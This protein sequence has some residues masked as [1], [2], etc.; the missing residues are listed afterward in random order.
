MTALPASSRDEPVGAAYIPSDLTVC[1]ATTSGKDNDKQGVRRGKA[2]CRES[3]IEPIA[4]NM[5]TFQIN[6]LFSAVLSEQVFAASTHVNGIFQI[7][8]SDK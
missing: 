7:H 4:I 5:R 2:M 8:W 3:E 1:H 6:F